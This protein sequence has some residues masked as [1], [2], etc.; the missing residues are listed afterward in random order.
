MPAWV[1][2]CNLYFGT[3]WTKGHLISVDLRPVEQPPGTAS[4]SLLICRIH[5]PDIVP[6]LV[7]EVPSSAWAATVNPSV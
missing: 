3:S 7:A 5:A 1:V 4:C 6:S 2:E